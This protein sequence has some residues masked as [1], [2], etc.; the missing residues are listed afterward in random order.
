M[1][2]MSYNITFTSQSAFS[3]SDLQK[4]LLIR[5]TTV[6]QCLLCSLSLMEYH[7][8]WLFISTDL[9]VL[10]CTMLLCTTKAGWKCIVYSLSKHDV[11][12]NYCNH[13]CC[14]SAQGS[15][16]TSVHTTGMPMPG[17]LVHVHAP[18]VLLYALAEAEVHYAHIMYTLNCVLLLSRYVI[19]N[20]HNN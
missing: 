2:A 17:K 11:L 12:H 16:S 18:S 14:D 6:I 4:Q 8:Q 7:K 9:I 20:N 15:M 19:N 3:A 13:H 10:C 1:P 5:Y